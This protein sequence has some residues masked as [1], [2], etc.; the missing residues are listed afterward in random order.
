MKRWLF[1]CFSLLL[2][3]ANAQDFETVFERSGGTQSVTYQ[4]L[5]KYYHELDEQYATIRM[6]EAGETDTYYPLYVVYYSNDAGFDIAEWKDKNKLIIL[7]NNGIHPGEPD[8]IDASMMLLRDAAQGKIKVPDNVVLA[9]IPVFNI[10]GMLNRGS[11]SRANQNGPQEYGFRGNAQNLDLNR[12][13]MKMDAKETQ[14]L[15]SLFRSLDPDIFIDNHVSD[16]ADYQHVMTLLTTQYDKLGGVMGKYLKENLEPVVYREMKKKG[17]D[18]VPYVNH[19]GHTPEQ[20]WLAFHEGPRFA[21]G[22]AA[23]YH[24]FSFVS[25]THMLK[26]FKQRVE[27]TYT[28]MSSFIR[29]AGTDGAEIQKTRAKQKAAYMKQSTIPIAWVPDSSSHSTI[30]FKGYESGFKPSDISGKPRLYYDREKPYTKQITYY[31]H[32]KASQTVVAPRAYYVPRGWGRVVD[33]LK[34][35]NIAMQEVQA[36]TM[37]QLGVYMIVGYETSPRPYEGH[38]LHSK[39]RVKYEKQFVKLYKGDYIVS[40]NQPSARYLV[41]VLEPTAPDAFF[42]WGFFDAVLQ[43]KEYFSDYVFEDEGARLLQADKA[44]QQ[45]LNEQKAADAKFAEDGEAQLDFVY[46]NSPYYEPVHMRY[47]VFRLD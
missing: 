13:F 9:V 10:G 2:A 40:L 11:Y 41:E 15:V 3:S 1:F 46:K 16:G 35:N 30:T 29:I 8:G 25:E 42:A 27:A 31:D 14:S 12:D 44:L 33:R 23:L 6:A 37:M 4:Q 21:S 32:Y 39:V 43:Q 22:F 38:Y 45:K 28:M 5:I 17:Y 36:D 20:G 18:L 19:W 26:P 47:P 7:I 24:T 34:V